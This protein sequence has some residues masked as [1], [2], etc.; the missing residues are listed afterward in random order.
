[1]EEQIFYHVLVDSDIY[2]LNELYSRPSKLNFSTFGNL[3]NQIEKNMPIVF[4]EEDAKNVATRLIT[5][6]RENGSSL[7]SNKSYP[8]FGALVVKMKLYLSNSSIKDIGKIQHDDSGKRLYTDLDNLSEKLITY[9]V[10]DRGN[11]E[12]KRGILKH[13]EFSNIKLVS[14]KYVKCDKVYDLGWGLLNS[15]KNLT[16]N[17]IRTLKYIFDKDKEIT[18]EH[19]LEGVKIMD[20][21]FEKKKITSNIIMSGGNMNDEMQLRRQVRD[22]KQKYLAMKQTKP[23][24]GGS[25]DDTESMRK[26]LH[27]LK[28]QYLSMKQTK[29]QIGGSMDDTESLRNKLHDLKKQYLSMK[30]TKPQMGGSMDDTE[31]MRK[32]L[33][34]VKKQY[35]AMKNN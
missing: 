21:D 16:S 11:I 2:M 15:F 35:L 12:V 26:K 9:S 20:I 29:P 31:S 14:I 6:I 13:S 17:D 4:D 30:Q 18:V 22:L 8:V 32:K 3:K 10:R 7:T 24:M 34:A 33:H 27:D 23:Q 28:K 1:M 25:M 19:T 5:S